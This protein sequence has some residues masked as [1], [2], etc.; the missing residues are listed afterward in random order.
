[1]NKIF[2]PKATYTIAASTVSAEVTTLDATENQI[3]I[4]NPTTSTVYIAFGTTA[5]TATP[6]S[7]PM[8]PGA[9]EVFTKANATRIAVLLS[10][11]T[12]TI[13]VTTGSGW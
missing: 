9:S 1:M 11:G 13:S 7:I 5:Q 6:S 3:R 4:H 2:E 8:G 12:G 10:T